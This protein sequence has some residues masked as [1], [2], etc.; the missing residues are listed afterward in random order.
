MLRGK[1]SIQKN[2]AKIEFIKKCK[3]YNKGTGFLRFFVIY[4]I[5]IYI[6][7]SV[8][9]IFA[10]VI[11]EPD[12]SIE[13]KIFIFLFELIKA[14]FMYIA[15]KETFL[16]SKKSYYFLYI[17]FAFICVTG[18]ITEGLG[19]LPLG[20]ILYFCFFAYLYGRSFSSV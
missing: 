12:F 1:K 9:T 15:R 3:E 5:P 4:A 13:E 8:M 17:T 20:I 6:V 11:N 14:V 7:L 10:L 18:L 2:P 19:S 16:L